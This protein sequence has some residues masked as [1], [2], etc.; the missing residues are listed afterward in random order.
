MP[1]VPCLAQ[2]QYPNNIHAYISNLE[3]LGIFQTRTDVY[4][5]GENI[6]EPL[7]NNA[8][9]AYGKI[10]A[11]IEDRVLDFKKGKIIITP[12]ARLFMSACFDSK[13]PNQSL[14]SERG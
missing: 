14:D 7:E 11:A 8:K 5:V 12:L 10:E 6:Y 2:L 1:G 9:L 13:S 3:G 4:M